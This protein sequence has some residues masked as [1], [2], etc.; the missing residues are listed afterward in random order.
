MK[1]SLS[2]WCGVELDILSPVPLFR[3]VL[4]KE[5]LRRQW[6]WTG[7]SHETSSELEEVHGR[8]KRAEKPWPAWDKS[9]ADVAHNPCVRPLEGRLAVARLAVS[10]FAI[11][12]AHIPRNAA[13]GFTTSSPLLL[14]FLSSFLPLFLSRSSFFGGFSFSSFSCCLFSFLSLLFLYFASLGF[15]HPELFCPSDHGYPRSS[16][17]CLW[18]ASLLLVNRFPFFVKASDT[19]IRC[20]VLFVYLPSRLLS[21]PFEI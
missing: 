4:S 1:I 21:R 6:T 14:F 7:L 8:K 12:F 2:R 19:L 10:V 11:R 13:F 3:F 17:L 15:S 16:S 9:S 20:V 5:C 18:F